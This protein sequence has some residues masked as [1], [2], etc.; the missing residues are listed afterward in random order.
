MDDR[1]YLGHNADQAGIHINL[2]REYFGEK[3][4]EQERNF[5]K[6]VVFIEM[7]KEKIVALSRRNKM[8]TERWCAYHGLMDTPIQTLNNYYARRNSAIN[9]R[10]K[11]RIE[12][13]LFRSTLNPIIF[14]ASI[15]FTHTVSLYVCE[16]DMDKMSWKDYCRYVAERGDCNE[17]MYY[18]KSKNLF[19]V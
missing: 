1:S 14:Y 13:R 3:H 18:L 8:Q 2:S 15:Q 10:P 17:L 19:Y 9:F 11:N 4:D 16:K 5:Q 7:N 6:L 12:F